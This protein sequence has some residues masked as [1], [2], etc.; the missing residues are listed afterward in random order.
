MLAPLARDID[1]VFLFTGCLLLRV[2]RHPVTAARFGLRV[3]DQGT[4]MWNARFKDSV[5]PAMLSGV[6]AHAASRMPA[7]PSAGAG[8]LLAAHAHA[9]GWPFPRG[10]AQSLADALVAD[11]E[12]HGGRIETGVR[13]ASLRELPPA[14]VTLLATSPRLLLT[15]EVPG[16]Y[17]RAI[18]RFRFGSG[19]AKV[20]FALDGPVPWAN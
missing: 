6:M 11:L 19:V 5:A 13:I 18:R 1:C 4:R 8:L 14:R 12:A 15:G 7:L 16:R 3:I 9:G 20:D 2:P 17:A 10:G